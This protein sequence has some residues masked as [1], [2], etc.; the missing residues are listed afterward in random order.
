MSDNEIWERRLLLK[1][2]ALETE[3]EVFYVGQTEKP[4]SLRLSQHMSASRAPRS[5]VAHFIAS[6]K[7]SVTIR[8]LEYMRSHMWGGG[9]RGREAQWVRHFE[10]AGCELKNVLFSKN[11]MRVLANRQPRWPQDVF[12]RF[13][14]LAVRDGLIP[15]APSSPTSGA[16][17]VDA[18]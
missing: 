6:L 2:Y 1:I 7:S 3:G 17:P 15:T 8:G 16:V 18:G 4:L 10:A 12:D 5:P 11:D 13:V 9:P 14:E